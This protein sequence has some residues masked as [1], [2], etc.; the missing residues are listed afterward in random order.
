[1]VDHYTLPNGVLKNRFGATTFEAF[2]K[3]EARTVPP[4]TARLTR[5]LEGFSGPFTYDFFC[6]VHRSL[7]GGLFDWAGT[8]RDVP[9]SKQHT[10]DANAITRFVSPGAIERRL[11][12]AIDGIPEIKH[13]R[14]L[15]RSAAVG[16]LA[17]AFAEI[18]YIHPFREGNGRTQR[19][20]LNS[21]AKAVGFN[22]EWDV[23]T[24]DRMVEVSIAAVEGDSQAV[25]RMFADI[26]D[27]ERVAALYKIT[28][29]L[30]A[31]DP[32]WNDRYI[33]TTV[34]GQAYVGVFG[35]VSGDDFMMKVRDSRSWFASGKI[36]DLEDLSPEPGDEL[37][38]TAKHWKPFG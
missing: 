34:E 36:D 20:F 3:V 18:N 33:A 24:R 29:F 22:L 5:E 10:V 8:I 12:S 23:I 28:R 6:A 26:V 37:S 16:K 9:I 15:K 19:F 32:N 13:L 31:N 21:I 30:Q 2:H 1:L 17:A 4:R 38:F 14:S 7:F 35:G 27:P 25:A 11:R